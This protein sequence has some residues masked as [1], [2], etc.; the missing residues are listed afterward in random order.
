MLLY[1]P[2]VFGA[3]TVII[4]GVVWGIRLEGRVNAQNQLCDTR[5]HYVDERHGEIAVRF[6]RTDAKIDKIDNKLDRLLEGHR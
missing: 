2:L 4:G 3:F 1:W 6:D 5:N